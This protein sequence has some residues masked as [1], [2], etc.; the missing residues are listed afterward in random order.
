V[1]VV[2]SG[3]SCP[4][5]GISIP[6]LVTL[7]VLLLA[8]C[9]IALLVIIKAQRRRITTGSSGLV[10]ETG[11]AINTLNPR[12]MVFVH[13]E[14]WRAQSSQGVIKKGEEIEVVDVERFRLKVIRTKSEGGA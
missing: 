5:L 13:G 8:G 9:L 6:L 14:Y 4:F 7:I 11:Y 3:Y 12:G 1:S 10:G 2:V